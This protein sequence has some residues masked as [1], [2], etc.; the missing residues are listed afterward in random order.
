MGNLCSSEEQAK[1]DEV[2]EKKDLTNIAE[3]SAK[4]EESPPEQRDDKPKESDK[5]FVPNSNNFEESNNM[6]SDLVPIA[7]MFDSLLG[8][9]ILDSLS[10][11]NSNLNRFS[12]LN[13]NL[14]NDK[15]V[16]SST[17]LG[18]DDPDKA[19]Y[20]TK[21]YVECNSDEE[22]KEYNSAGSTPNTIIAPT[23]KKKLA[24]QKVA[25]SIP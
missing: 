1:Q 13:L 21:G 15:T 19:G 8:P 5:S 24:N 17:K 6:T 3:S 23:E 9:L 16:N 20:L 10:R 14:S 11:D 12:P 7:T 25:L 22:F 4:Q 2:S 18:S